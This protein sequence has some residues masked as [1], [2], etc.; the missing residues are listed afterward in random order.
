M[1]VTFRTLERAEIGKLQEV[2]RREI[3]NGIYQM[4]DSE[5]QLV[6][7]FPDVFITGTEPVFRMH[8]GTLELVPGQRKI[9]GFNEIDRRI[10]FLTELF[11][12]GGMLFGAFD[13]ATLVGLSVLE[14]RLRGSHF[15]HMQL[16]GLWVSHDYRRQGIGKRLVNLVKAAARERGASYLYICSFPSTNTIHFYQSIG[17]TPAVELDP[18]LFAKEPDDIHFELSLV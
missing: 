3:I 16:S 2:D 7:G 6:D 14:N 10:L 18:E 15:N 11:D 4:R 17:C 5:L 13:G 1:E 8:E 9:A 12:A